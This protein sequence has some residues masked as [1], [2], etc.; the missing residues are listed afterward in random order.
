[1]SVAMEG[2]RA[3]ILEIQALVCESTFP[4]P[5]R[6]A[7]GF[8]SNRLTM[9]LALL[10]KKLDLPF[11]RYDVF[12]NISGG[13]KIKES[14]ADLAVIAAIISSFRNRPIS[15][16]SVFIG[17]VSLTGE[18]KDVFSME[19]RLKEASAQGIT[20]AI[21]ATKPSIKIDMKCFV[22]DEVA[23]MIELF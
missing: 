5:K 14:S 19:N 17:E 12:V 16:E 6:S 23:K 15:K 3:I 13:I 20:K 21:I 9:L 7:T 8:D 10:E 11:N 18:I 1:L 2:S 22:V 4:N